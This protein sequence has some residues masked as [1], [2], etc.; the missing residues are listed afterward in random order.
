MADF[1]FTFSLHFLI[2]RTFSQ[3][4]SSD[5]DGEEWRPPESKSKAANKTAPGAKPPVKRT[6]KPKEP[7]PPRQPKEPKSKTSQKPPTKR[8]LPTSKDQ[9]PVPS[10]L[11]RTKRRKG[12]ESKNEQADYVDRPEE[13]MTDEP[14]PSIRMKD[15]VRFMVCCKE[16]SA[17]SY[18]GSIISAYS[19]RGSIIHIK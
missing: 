19:Y 4:M 3:S 12:D 1:F 6:A 17:Y 18:R 14:G 7:K 13:E 11:A 2:I 5:E 15:E 8:K 16:M 9:D 10:G